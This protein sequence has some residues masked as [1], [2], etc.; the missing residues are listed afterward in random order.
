M[1]I[2]SA[3]RSALG[4]QPVGP[5]PD[6]HHKWHQQSWMTFSIWAR[7]SWDMA[8]TSSGGASKISSSCTCS[9]MR[10]GESA[11]PDGPMDP[12]HGQLDQVGGRALKR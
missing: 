2:L 1:Q 9:S 8:S 10:L 3:Q 6:V 5:D 7:T 4:L 12:D 11:F